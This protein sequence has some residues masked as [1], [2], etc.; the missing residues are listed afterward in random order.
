MKIDI[1]YSII[2][3]YFGNDVVSVIEVRIFLRLFFIF[4]LLFE[5]LSTKAVALP[6][7]YSRIEK[8]KFITGSFVTF[9]TIIQ[10]RIE[11]G[12]RR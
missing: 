12:G 2:R 1:M 3:V 6:N 5:T 11:K 4:F 7:C 8:S 10:I 9:I